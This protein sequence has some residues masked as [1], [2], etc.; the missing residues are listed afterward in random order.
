MAWAELNTLRS[1]TSHA[2]E[3]APY[4]IANAIVI[5]EAA[6]PSAAVVDVLT[7]DGVETKVRPFSKPET[8]QEL[9][10]WVV[11]QTHNLIPKIIDKLPDEG[12]IVTLN[13]LYF[14]DRWKK[15]FNPADTKTTPFR[16]VGGKTVDARMMQSDNGKF[17]FYRDKKFDAVDLPYATEGY[18][19]AIVT[20]KG[21]PG[22][23]EEFTGAAELLTGK[24]YTDGP[25]DVRIPRLDLSGNN[26]L[27]GTILDLMKGKNGN[28]N[29]TVS[30]FTSKPVQLAN[31]QQRV[32]LKLD[33]EGTEAAAATALSMKREMDDKYFRFFADRPFVFALRDAKT[34]LILV[35]GYVAQPS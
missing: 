31:A 28:G 20:T 15:T 34:G 14:K 25:G 16:M 29:V 30:R 33:E 24:G 23:M 19:I 35:A 27:K 9:N 7:G 2:A 22:S 4:T 26:N 13:A 18:S 8:L 3:G 1:I 17:K 10:D 12:G 6:K 11:K 32:V 5:D 21:E